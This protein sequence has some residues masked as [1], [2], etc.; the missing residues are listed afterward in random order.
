M[1]AAFSRS[2]KQA[3]EEHTWVVEVGLVA[4]DDVA[5]VGHDGLLSRVVVCGC[6]TVFAWV[7]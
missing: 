6:W 1:S 7:R 4:T 2:P 3:S 5:W